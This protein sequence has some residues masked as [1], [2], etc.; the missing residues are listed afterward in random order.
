MIC[1]LNVLISPVYCLFLLSKFICFTVL[2]ENEIRIRGIVLFS[3]KKSFHSLR[4][5]KALIL[6]GAQ[7]PF[8]C[9]RQNVA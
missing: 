5:K 4:T 2:L 7:M 6:G 8:L 9:I 1:N 3:E